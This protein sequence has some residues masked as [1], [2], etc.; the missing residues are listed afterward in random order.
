MTTAVP[1]NEAPAVLEELDERTQ[2]AWATY[3]DT[4]RDLT[5]RAYDEAE[6]EAWDR[7]Q[8]EL[9][10]VEQTRAELAASRA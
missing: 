6:A 8:R 5:G 4:L 7:L 9:G 10:D 2:E 1:P 3:S